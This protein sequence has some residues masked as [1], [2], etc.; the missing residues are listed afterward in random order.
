MTIKLNKTNI[1]SAAI[2]LMTVAVLEMGW[3]GQRGD[4]FRRLLGQSRHHNL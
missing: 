3:S 1:S 4:R 2:W